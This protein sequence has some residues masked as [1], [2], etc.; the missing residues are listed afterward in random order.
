MREKGRERGEE[1]ERASNKNVIMNIKY[2]QHR[3]T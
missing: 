3:T 1:K 2:E